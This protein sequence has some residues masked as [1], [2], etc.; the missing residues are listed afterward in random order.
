[1]CQAV[2][3]VVRPVVV[4]VV[5]RVV[6]RPRTVGRLMSAVAT[7]MSAGAVVERSDNNEDGVT[8]ME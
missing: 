3:V 5:R 4:V 7:C 6:S 1:M 8:G 2:V